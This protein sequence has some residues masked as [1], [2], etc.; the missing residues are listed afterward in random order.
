[1]PKGGSLDLSKQGFLDVY[2][3]SYGVARALAKR[4]RVWVLTFELNRDAAEDLLSETVQ[5]KIIELIKMKAFLAVG[6]GPVCTSM[7]R[8]VRPPVRSREYWGG[9]PDYERESSCRE[10]TR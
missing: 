2:S 7:S 6:G 1:M 9:L 10:S 4:A 3:G 8:A 5:A